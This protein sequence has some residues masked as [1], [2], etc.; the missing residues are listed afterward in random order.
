MSL[1]T[2]YLSGPKN[3][4]TNEVINKIGVISKTGTNIP[5]VPVALGIPIIRCIEDGGIFKINRGYLLRADSSGYDP[6]FPQ[7]THDPDDEFNE[8]GS[9]Y[10]ILNL[11]NSHLLDHNFPY[12][13]TSDFH[14]EADETPSTVVV[15][16]RLGGAL[17]VKGTSNQVSTVNKGFN[18]FRGGLRI[19]FSHALIFVVKLVLSHSTALLFRAGINMTLV[20]SVDAGQNQVGIEGCTSGSS[21][22]QLVSGNGSSRTGLELPSAALN[23]A[24]FKGYKVEF[25]PGDKVVLTDGL[26]NSITKTTNLPTSSSSPDADAT[27]RIGLITSNNVSKILKLASMRLLGKVFD[28]NP[29]IGGWV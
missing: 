28:T 18:L 8:G 9:F 16:E 23:Y 12:V 20:Q 22:F 14:I 2:N 10:N 29:A 26:G 27:I 15:N 3:T 6:L 13:N 4:I 25:F 1:E 19:D 21:N 5:G 7:H 11:N 17:Y 24:N